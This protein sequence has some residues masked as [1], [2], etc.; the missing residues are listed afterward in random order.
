MTAVELLRAAAATPANERWH[1]LR[2]AGVS[3]S[4]IAVV[5]GISPFESAFSLYW[6]KVNGWDVEATDEMRAGQILEPAI[7]SWFE[8]DGDPLQNLTFHRAGLYASAERPW[9]LATPDRLVYMACPGCDGTGYDRGPCEDCL[10][11]GIGSPLLALV[12]CKWVAYSW[13]GWGEPGTDEI[14]VYYRAQTQQQMDVLDVDEVFVPVLGPGGFRAYRVR[15]DPK[16]IRVLRAAGE[17]FMNRLA[18]GDPPDIDDHITTAAALKRLHP[19]LENRDVDLA[20]VDGGLALAEGYRRA[21]ALRSRI[22][23]T[24]DRYEARI[25]HT[26]GAANRLVYG[27]KLVASRSI[28]EQAGDSAE[29]TALEGDWPVVDRLNPGR[30]KTYA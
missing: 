1:E 7:A 27:K 4:E 24:V 16:D 20:D 5:L 6:R 14:P 23:S 12:E 18:D 8:D 30:S 9:Q 17:A 2:R 29:L 15:R 26:L 19:S 28:Y 3:A 25:R 21:R 10:R 11:T 22:E 13:D